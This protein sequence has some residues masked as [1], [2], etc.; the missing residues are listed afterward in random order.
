MVA[1][2]GRPRGPADRAETEQVACD[3]GAEARTTTVAEM[4]DTR[5]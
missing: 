1:S 4:I 3:S 2:A 5:E